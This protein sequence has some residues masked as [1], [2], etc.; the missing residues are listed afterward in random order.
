MTSTVDEMSLVPSLKVISWLPADRLERP[1]DRAL[2]DVLL[3]LLAVD[4]DGEVSLGTAWTIA[5]LP[6]GAAVAA[7]GASWRIAGEAGG[8]DT[9]GDH[10]RCGRCCGPNRA[11]VH[12]GSPLGTPDRCPSPLSG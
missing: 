9:A 5:T 3:D 12:V 11:Y 8:G 1:D 2:G 4:G 7:R 6:D 10:Q